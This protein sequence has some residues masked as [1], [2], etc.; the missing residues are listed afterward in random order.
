VRVLI[1]HSRYRSG[2]VSGE[3]RV[4]A[5]EEVL[6][7]RGGH[8]VHIWT[9]TPLGERLVDQARAGVDV[10]WSPRA[11]RELRRLIV[12]HRPDVV[13][14]HNLFPALSPAVVRVASRARLPVVVSLHN[15]RLAC[16][17]ATFLRNGRICEACLGRLPWRGALY[18]CYRDSRAASSAL[19]SSLTLHR[20]L[21]TFD[22]VTLFLAVSRFVQ[23]KHIEA[24]IQGD[25]IR[26][27]PN[28]AWPSQRRIEAGNY[29]LYLGRLSAEKGITALA[30]AWAPGSGKLLIVGSGPDGER[31]RAMASENV[32]VRQPVPPSRVPR[33]LRGARALLVPSLCYE[34]APRGVIEAYAAGVPVVASRIGA[35]AE[36]V[37][38]DVSGLLLPPGDQAAWID[39]VKR[40]LDDGEA[41]RLGRGALALWERDYTPERG[42]ERLEDAYRDA[43]ATV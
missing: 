22:D 36:L 23:E 5:D 12:E 43:M 32:E 33:L 39:G 10:M 16:L 8:D 38:D 14:V 27:K 19:A 11:V 40:L 29:L 18:G 41:D 2:S 13:H 34:G 1:L 4:V 9:P 30:S 7:R 6:L 3:N 21:G 20:W 24:G 35:L 37:E 26:V 42:L 31:L 17:P 28:F 25:R 15:Y